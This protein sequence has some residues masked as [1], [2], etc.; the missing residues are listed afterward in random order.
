MNVVAVELLA[1]LCEGVFASVRR[2]F[3]SKLKQTEPKHTQ[4]E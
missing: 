4:L 1:D 2:D 3:T